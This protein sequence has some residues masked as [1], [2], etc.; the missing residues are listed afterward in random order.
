M[1]SQH[2]EISLRSVGRQTQRSNEDDLRLVTLLQLDGPSRELA[3]LLKNVEEGLKAGSSWWRRILWRLRWPFNKADIEEDLKKIESQSSVSGSY[4]HSSEAKFGTGSTEFYETQK[5]GSAESPALWCPGSCVGNTILA[6]IIVDHLQLLPMDRDK[7]TLILKNVLHSL[8]KQLIQEP[9][10]SPLIISLYNNRTPLLLDTL[11]NYFSQVLSSFCHVYIILDAL[12]EFPD[13]DGGWE[14]LINALQTLG[15]NISLLVM[16][17]DI[18]MKGLLFTRLNIQAA[19]EDISLYI[20]S[21]LS[22]GHLAYLVEGQ[23]DL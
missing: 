9:G 23:K 1:E 18:S 7:K 11:T 12:D 5:N 19:D 2:L 6:S 3:M 13:N 4:A 15:I 20:A 8:W 16:T 17:R 21:K 22:G 10:L 14:K